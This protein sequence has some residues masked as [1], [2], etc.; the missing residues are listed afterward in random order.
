MAQSVCPI[1]FFRSRLLANP[2]RSPE[3]GKKSPYTFSVPYGSDDE[4]PIS[5]T[6]SVILMEQDLPAILKSSP[7]TIDLTTT[8]SN[9]EPIIDLTTEPDV[10]TDV[11]M[12]GRYSPIPSSRGS[13]STS[14]AARTEPMPLPAGALAAECTDVESDEDENSSSRASED[15]ED[16]PL[17][18][19]DAQSID[20]DDSARYT[21]LSE[22]SEDSLSD[23]EMGSY[24][25][26]SD[27][28]SFE[29][30]EDDSHGYD[31]EATRTFGLPSNA[32]QDATGIILLL[33]PG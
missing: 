9:A 26:D 3:Q 12:A 5:D 8:E 30:D 24:N 27:A 11:S 17:L 32:F 14:P 16:L 15:P 4:D 7:T 10:G 1:L 21:S 13:Q 25:E 22:E 18:A 2:K 31:W 20:S 19:E 29:D 6:D 33:L 23:S 28:E